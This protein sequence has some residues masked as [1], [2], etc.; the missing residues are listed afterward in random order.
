MYISAQPWGIQGHFAEVIERTMFPL[1]LKQLNT[2]Q[3]RLFPFSWQYSIN[4]KLRIR[5]AFAGWT[6]MPLHCQAVLMLILVHVRY[7]GAA[8]ALMPLHPVFSRDGN[9]GENSGNVKFHHMSMVG[10]IAMCSEERTCRGPSRKDSVL[11]VPLYIWPPK[12][13]QH[14]SSL[15][16]DKPTT[17]YVILKLGSLILLMVW[18]GKTTQSINKSKEVEASRMYQHRQLK[19]NPSVVFFSEKNGIFSSSNL[20]EVRMLSCLL[21]QETE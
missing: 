19:N 20:T 15:L 14:P 13:S 4:V 12:Y 8:K 2:A 9:R 11:L 21:H 3:K 18:M 17:M 10:F 6:L 1:L 5:S 7:H 16:K